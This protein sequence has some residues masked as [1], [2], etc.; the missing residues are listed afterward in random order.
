MSVAFAL[1]FRSRLIAAAAVTI[2][3]AALLVSH[4]IREKHARDAR[5]FVLDLQMMP[6]LANG[7]AIEAGGRAKAADPTWEAYCSRQRDA[8]IAETRTSSQ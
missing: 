2:V 3:L 4:T 8:L 5:Q 1:G 6:R 7:Y